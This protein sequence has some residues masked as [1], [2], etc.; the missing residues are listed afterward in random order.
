MRLCD[1]RRYAPVGVPKDGHFFF[2]SLDKVKKGERRGV[3][4]LPSAGL[5]EIDSTQSSSEPV[6]LKCFAFQ[7]ATA[8]ENKNQFITF[9]VVQITHT[10]S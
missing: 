1:S 5:I 8:E 2:S 10:S 3:I 4:G 7:N 9:K 6:R